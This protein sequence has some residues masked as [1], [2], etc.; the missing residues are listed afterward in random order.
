MIL[1]FTLFRHKHH[2]PSPP[3]AVLTFVS[4]SLPPSRKAKSKQVCPLLLLRASVPPILMG[5]R[6]PERPQQVMLSK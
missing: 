2:T 3:V 5:E 6:H 1:E 4:L